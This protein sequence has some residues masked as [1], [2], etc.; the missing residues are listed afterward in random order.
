MELLI[1]ETG[2]D[3]EKDPRE[4][5]QQ[6]DE[7]FEEVTFDRCFYIYGGPEYLEVLLLLL[8]IYIRLIRS[9]MG[10]KTFEIILEFRNWRLY[11]VTTPCC[12]TE[13]KQNYYLSKSHST[14]ASLNRYSK[15]LGWILKL[16]KLWMPRKERKLKPQRME[17][18]MR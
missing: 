12:L 14:I 2:L 13:K 17:I 5:D 7:Q 15:L 8:S 11:Q 1:S 9:S 6:A 3:I 10:S 4:A 18:A 16:R